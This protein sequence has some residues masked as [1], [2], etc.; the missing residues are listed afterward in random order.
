MTIQELIEL[1]P[2]HQKIK[3]WDDNVVK[4]IRKDGW[5]AAPGYMPWTGTVAEFKKG[6]PNDID[7]GELYKALVGFNCECTELFTDGDVLH[8]SYYPNWWC[9]ENCK[10]EACPNYEVCQGG[11]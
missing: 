5:H 3:V 7:E 8:I 1:L 4:A 6:D 2:P 9:Y 10:G 11:T